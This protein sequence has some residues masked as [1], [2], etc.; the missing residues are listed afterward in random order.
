MHIHVI[1]PNDFCTNY[2]LIPWLRFA[3]CV[4]VYPL[5]L[6]PSLVSS[7]LFTHSLPSSPLFATWK[8]GNSLIPQPP[9][10]CVQDEGQSSALCSSA[11]SLPS[12]SSCL[13]RRGGKDVLG[14]DP[15]AEA[16]RAGAAPGRV[17]GPPGARP[18]PRLTPALL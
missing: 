17:G 14:L 18:S 7:L 15:R 6:Q 16:A 1:I 10:V 12:L 4:V 3:V 13:A 5:V 8:T 11:V 2:P 9:D